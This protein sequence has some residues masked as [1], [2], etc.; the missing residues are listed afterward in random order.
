MNT[1]KKG[2]IDIGDVILNFLGPQ[3]NFLVRI[4]ELRG[5]CEF[6]VPYEVLPS[7]LAKFVEA[8]PAR[9]F[10]G[11]IRAEVPERLL[12]L[13]SAIC[14][15]EGRPEQPCSPVPEADS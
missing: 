6:V 5:G 3:M 14:R 4:T 12:Q 9:V 11:S 13:E 7:D 2:K 1:K 10:S 15:T 8:K